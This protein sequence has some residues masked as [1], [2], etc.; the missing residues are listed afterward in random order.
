MHLESLVYVVVNGTRIIPNLRH[1]TYKH[2][3]KEAS[4][5]IECARQ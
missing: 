2:N 1:L 3:K 5:F 4:S